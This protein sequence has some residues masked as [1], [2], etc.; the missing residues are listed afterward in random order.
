MYIK[1]LPYSRISVVPWHA[2]FY[3][4]S[5]QSYEGGIVILV[6][7]IMKLIWTSQ[8]IFSRSHNYSLISNKQSLNSN[9]VLST[10]F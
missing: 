10:K 6:L 1:N 5:K 7:L 9:L 4:S 8:I 3:F 2:L